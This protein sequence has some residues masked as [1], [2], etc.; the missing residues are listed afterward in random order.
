MPCASEPN[1]VV[2]SAMIL[3]P[4]QWSLPWNSY[5]ACGTQYWI[6]T[7]PGGAKALGLSVALTCCM[8]TQTDKEFIVKADIPGV[9]KDQIKVR[10]QASL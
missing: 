6:R 7:D 10:A 8:C 3:V 4:K 2:L 1:H 5:V 9:R